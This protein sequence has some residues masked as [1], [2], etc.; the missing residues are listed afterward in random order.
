MDIFY[1]K[2]L[3]VGKVSIL[4]VWLCRGFFE[5]RSGI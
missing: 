3:A 1:S 5:N 2:T 4:G